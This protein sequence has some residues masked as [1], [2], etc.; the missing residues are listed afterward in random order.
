MD[1][2]IPGR[3]E[4]DNH[5]LLFP[6]LL[7]VA[8]LVVA[9]ST[10]SVIALIGMIPEPHSDAAQR[11]APESDVERK[12]TQS[13][14]KTSRRQLTGGVAGV[15]ECCLSAGPVNNVAYIWLSDD[16]RSAGVIWSDRRT[17]I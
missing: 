4:S 11:A 14:E 6:L 16:R 2:T 1:G 17:R 13:L 10:L 7:I 15:I 8:M 12:P 5:W 3:K 9:L